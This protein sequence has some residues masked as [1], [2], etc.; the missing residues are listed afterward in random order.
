MGKDGTIDKLFSRRDFLAATVVAPFV[1]SGAA[2][3]G[4]VSLASHNGQIRFQLHDGLEL[5]YRV[6][7]KNNAVIEN[8]RLG[9]VID[10]VNLGKDAATTGV[11]KYRTNNEY[12]WRGVHAKAVDRSNGAKIRISHT[13]TK[14]DYTLDERVFDDGVAFRSL[15]TDV[16]RKRIP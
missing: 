3:E 8:S 5:T 16:H 7:F 13:S 9:M 10:G 11:E 4:T 6:S 14:I 12:A 2:G 15:I 1:V